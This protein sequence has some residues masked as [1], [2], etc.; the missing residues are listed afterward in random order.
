MGA[1]PASK[2]NFG[3]DDDDGN[4]IKQAFSNNTAVTGLFKSEEDQA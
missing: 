1:G 2:P 3:N 4:E